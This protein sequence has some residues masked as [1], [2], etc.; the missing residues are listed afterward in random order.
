[1]AKNFSQDQALQIYL[2]AIAKYGIESRK[3]ML[4]EEC[5]ELI[6][7]LARQTRGRSTVD[8]ILS[9]LAD[10]FIMVNQ[11]G[12]IYGYPAFSQMVNMKLE[13]LE[14]RLNEADEQTTDNNN[15]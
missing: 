1:M 7:A 9:E 4:Y 15:P 14:K 11:L 2:Q 5:G 6:T 12:F 13:R 3:Q 8:D 10:V